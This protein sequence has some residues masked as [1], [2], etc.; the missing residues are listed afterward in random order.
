M[1]QSV[2]PFP[3]HQKKTNTLDDLEDLVKRLNAHID[4]LDS[5]VFKPSDERDLDPWATH[6]PTHYAALLDRLQAVCSCPNKRPPCS[7]NVLPA[8]DVPW[9]DP[10]EPFQTKKPE[11]PLRRQYAHW[12]TLLKCLP[13]L[14]PTAQAQVCAVGVHGMREILKYKGTGGLSS[15]VKLGPTE[16]E[17][18]YGRL[19]DSMRFPST[20]KTNG[21]A[22]ENPNCAASLMSKLNDSTTLH[23]LYESS[24]T[25][26]MNTSN[27]LSRSGGLYRPNGSSSLGSRMSPMT[28]SSLES[29]CVQ[30]PGLKRWLHNHT[31]KKTSNASALDKLAGWFK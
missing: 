26:G 17:N 23:M 9:L 31:R 2:S 3:I 29:L 6:I 28:Q 16:D 12:C 7:A 20:T 27:G 4:I 10:V 14:D 13:L 1:S 25:L 24:N 30:K 11:D 8:K 22:N 19:R 18:E 15:D 21:M 5:H